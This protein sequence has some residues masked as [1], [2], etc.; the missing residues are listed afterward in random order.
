MREP[1]PLLS[2][3]LCTRNRGDKIGNAVA[4]ILAG[5][6]EDFEL[7]VVDQSTDERT[8]EVVA[9]VGDTRVRYIRTDTVGLSR[10]RNIAVRESRAEIIVFTDDDCVCDREWL[11]GIAA[12]YAADPQLMGV[13]G[14]VLPYGDPPP[15]M[16]C[17]CII[18]SMERRT[19]DRPVIPYEVLGHGNNMSFRKEVFRLVGLYVESLGAGTWMKGGEDTDLI[20]RALRQRMKFA[21]SPEPLVYHDNW[22]PEERA[23]EL[24]CGYI[25][26]AVAVFT[27]F[28][29]R[30]DWRAL[31]HV[32]F[33]GRIITE[34]IVYFLRHYDTEKL[35]IS[36]AMLRWYFTGLAMGV[37]FAGVAPPKL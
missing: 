15:G 36:L 18:E 11:A 23:A 20:Y 8:Q 10:S 5:D 9:S 2:V 7:L 30:G 16:I 25:L 17:H 21:Y 12:E 31:G 6:F 32:L 33:R 22:M 4:T 35:G 3:L 29:L 13:Y 37:R 19:V 14:R 27:K 28:A 24:E 1:S 26:A 34:R